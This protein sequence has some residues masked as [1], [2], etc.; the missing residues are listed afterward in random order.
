MHPEPLN[1]VKRHVFLILSLLYHCQ[2]KGICFLLLFF[3]CFCEISKDPYSKMFSAKWPQELRGFTSA[4]CFA[5]CKDMEYNVGFNVVLNVFIEMALKM[6]FS[7]CF[8]M[9]ITCFEDV[10]LNMF[11]QGH[12]LLWSFFFIMYLSIKPFGFSHFTSRKTRILTMK[13]NRE[14]GTKAMNGLYASCLSYEKKCIL[15]F[16]F[17]NTQDTVSK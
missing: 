7:L 1:Q 10:F 16:I 15:R 12:N 17:Q 6:F 9:V 11:Q 2:N 8:S 13:N 5:L 3:I 14:C 4:R